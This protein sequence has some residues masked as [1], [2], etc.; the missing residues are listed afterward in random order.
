[1]FAWFIILFD[2]T[3]AALGSK[4]I[5]LPDFMIGLAEITGNIIWMLGLL[6]FIIAI[7]LILIIFEESG[8]MKSTKAAVNT[9][10]EKDMHDITPFDLVNEKGEKLFKKIQLRQKILFYINTTFSLI[11]IG[12]GFWFTGTCWLLLIISTKIYRKIAIECA[13]DIIKEEMEKDNG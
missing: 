6:F 8:M 4:L 1:M 7:L 10:T 11:A 2:P 9:I 12:S 5:I 3:A 13:E